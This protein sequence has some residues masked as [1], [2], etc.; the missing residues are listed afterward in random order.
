[1]QNIK[2]WAFLSS[3]RWYNIL[4]IVL[5]QYISA[6]FVFNSFPESLLTV[7]YDIN[8][9]LIVLCTMLVVSGG[10]LINDFYDFERDLIARP[11][12]TLLHQYVSK[13]ARLKLYVAF[14]FLAF[15][16]ALIGSFQILLYFIALSIGLWTYS[17]KFKKIPLIKEIW[18]SLLTVSCFFSVALRYDFF[19]WTVTYYGVYFVLLLF[20]RQ[21]VKGYEEIKADLVMSNLSIAGILG[22]KKTR[23]I[24]QFSIVF[25]LLFSLFLFHQFFPK[26]WLYYIFISD[27][28]L[29]GIFLSLFKIRHGELYLINFIYK[30]LIVLGILNLSVL[31]V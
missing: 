5:A 19:D 6:F 25:Q 3:V 15:I 1:M 16:L 28:I 9:H 14:N 22:D 18:A 30:I 13:N 2:L 20:T 7:T 4:L 10:F 23:T 26:I 31:L 27:V 21:I 12:V 11:K 8:L 24:I 17:H 29:V